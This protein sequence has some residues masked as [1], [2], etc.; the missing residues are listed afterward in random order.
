MYKQNRKTGDHKDNR[1]N[2]ANGMRSTS[3]NDLFLKEELMRAL[4]DSGFEHPSEG[5]VKNRTFKVLY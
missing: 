2:T 3:F 4:K 5:E 1:P